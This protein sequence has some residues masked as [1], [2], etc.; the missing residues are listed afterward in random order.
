MSPESI[1][2]GQT[3]RGYTLVKALREEALE[4]ATEHRIELFTRAADEIAALVESE[5]QLA[6]EIA[7]LRGET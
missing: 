1:L 5:K 4:C 6:N 7:K 2:N 3:L